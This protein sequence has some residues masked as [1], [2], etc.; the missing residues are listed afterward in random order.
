M[1]NRLCVYVVNEYP[2]YM[3]MVVNS[4]QMLRKYNS[5]IRVKV[6]F[7]T[8]QG[9]GVILRSGI[10]PFEFSSEK[11]IESCQQLNAEIVYCELLD[12]EGYF[13]AHRHYLKDCEE[14]SIFHIDSDTFIFGDVEQMFEVYKDVDFVACESHWYQKLPSEVLPITPFNSGVM[15]WNNGWLQKW[16]SGLLDTLD[17]LKNN[18]GETQTEWLYTHEKDCMGREEF[19]VSKFVV[20]FN[21]K[22][23]YFKDEECKVALYPKDLELAENSLIF[24]TLTPNWRSVYRRL[25]NI[26]P[27]KVKRRFINVNR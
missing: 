7:I 6:F 13:Y 21:L 12:V 15:L 8:D 5:S 1:N 22:F 11:F 27:T 16:S 4:L 19:S 10:S 2:F 23:S 3:K 20:D 9:K 24:H 18:R 25:N 14:S 26:S 17:K